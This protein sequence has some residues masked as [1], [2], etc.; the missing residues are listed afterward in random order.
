L[1]FFKCHVHYGAAVLA[2][3]LLPGL[4][5]GWF[6]FSREKSIKSFM[7]AFVFPIWFLPYS[8]KKLYLAVKKSTKADDSTSKEEEHAKVIKEIEMSLESYPQM[9]FGAFM[10][11]GLKIN[12]PLN[13]LS[14]SIS[15][16][17]SVY[18]FAD[19]LA[20]EENNEKVIVEICHIF[21]D[22]YYFLA[23]NIKKSF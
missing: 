8:I 4:F 15:V 16:A 12:Q 2:F 18:G 6:A 17:S 20:F 23:Q 5:Y 11:M 14:F 3:V 1:V 21:D 19:M 22:F 9:I 13:Y 10:I 7:R